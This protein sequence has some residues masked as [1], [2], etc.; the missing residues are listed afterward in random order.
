[1]LTNEIPV[2]ILLVD[3][4]PV[5]LFTLNSTLAALDLEV[6]TA[7]SAIEALRHL[8][9]QEFAVILLDVHMPEMDG[10]EAAQLIR[11][12]P[13]TEH[14]P[15]IF[16]TAISTSDTERARGYRLGAVDYLHMP[17]VPDILRAKVSA[18]V[19]LYRKTRQ[20]NLQAEELSSL[21]R[22]LADKLARIEMLNEELAG[23]Y[24]E[25]ESFSYS[26]SHDL[27]APLR[28]A[29]GFS[30]LLLTGTEELSEKSR[31]YLQ[32]IALGL[33]KMDRLI[34]DLLNLSRVTS[35]PMRMQPVNLGNLAREVLPELEYSLNRPNL[36]VDIQDDLMVMGD[37]DLLRVALQNL[38]GNA[39]KFTSKRDHALVQLAGAPG[40]EGMVTCYVKDD[41]AGFSPA[42]AH[43]LFT[44]FQ[45]LHTEDDFP[46]TGIGLATVQRIIRRHGGKIRAEGEVDQG[47]T[48]SFSL[49]ARADTA[50]N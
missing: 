13:A 25:L 10:F 35:L 33:E 32:N 9:H 3:D 26:V 17:I 36:K 20:V 19:D 48:F 5:K 7:R 21:N 41:G 49:P 40:P 4:N 2:K 24:H 28:A 6:V 23:A 38:L 46:G 18:F 43:K 30:Q 50:G 39:L 27:R 8:L 31:K 14:T 15:I 1:M 22:E 37:P 45:R 42:Y 44:P 47:A 34:A 12:R 29:Q 11:Q 16:V